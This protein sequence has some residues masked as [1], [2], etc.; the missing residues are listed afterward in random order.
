MS[1]GRNRAG[2]GSRFQGD[3]NRSQRWQE[4]SHRPSELLPSPSPWLKRFTDGFIKMTIGRDPE[5]VVPF[6]NA[7]LLAGTI[8]GEI[9]VAEDANGTIVGGAVWFGPG[10]EFCHR[11]VVVGLQ[12]FAS[13]RQTYR[14][15]GSSFPVKHSKR[16]SSYRFSPSLTTSCRHGGTTR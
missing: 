9:H 10:S 1:N 11:L 15:I 14:L 5:L 3:L 13:C 8:E 7:V 4:A 2:V 16:G 12:D 6:V